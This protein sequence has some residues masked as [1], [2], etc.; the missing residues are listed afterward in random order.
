MKVPTIGTI[1]RAQVSVFRCP[2]GTTGYVK[3]IST[4][5]NGPAVI[6]QTFPCGEIA[7][8]ARDYPFFFDEEQKNP[9][10]PLSFLRDV[11][12]Q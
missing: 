3:A 11:P 7:V 12:A 8:S 6:I 10:L 9:E 5:C 2:E 4:G 1:V